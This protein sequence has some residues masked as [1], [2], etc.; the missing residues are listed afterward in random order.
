[1][2]S[3]VD[4]FFF[5]GGDTDLLLGSFGGDGGRPSGIGF[6]RRIGDGGRRPRL[7]GVIWGSSR[8]SLSAAL[9]FSF[10]SFRFFE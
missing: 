10:S 1:M 6:L 3:D 7:S 2:S 4:A 8:T 9:S 5:F